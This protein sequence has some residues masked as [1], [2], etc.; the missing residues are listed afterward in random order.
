MVHQYRDTLYTAQKQTHLT[1]SL[2]QD[3]AIFN[4]HIS[5]KFDEWLTDIETAA[6]LLSES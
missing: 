6:D 3:I 1:N 4:E 2:L 5:T